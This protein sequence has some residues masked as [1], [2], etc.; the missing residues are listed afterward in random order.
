MSINNEF[1]LQRGV[2]CIIGFFLGAF[3]NT[4]T[5]A[6]AASVSYICI[7]WFR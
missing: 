5:A 4:G 2:E 6:H 1:A 3:G 7:L